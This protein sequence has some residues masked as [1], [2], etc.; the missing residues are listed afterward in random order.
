MV[1]MVVMVMVVAHSKTCRLRTCRRFE[2]S[3]LQSSS[4]QLADADNDI[5]L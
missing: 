3:F 1:V 4:T 5:S 2:S